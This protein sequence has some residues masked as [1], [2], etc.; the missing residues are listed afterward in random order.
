MLRIHCVL[1]EWHLLIFIYDIEKICFGKIS[2]RTD[3]VVLLF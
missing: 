3:Y 1:L 2:K